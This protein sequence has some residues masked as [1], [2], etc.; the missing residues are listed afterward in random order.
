MSPFQGFIAMRC[1]FVFI[2]FLLPL[3]AFEHFEG[4]HCHPVD[5]TPDGRLLLAVNAPEGRLSVFSTANP[6]VPPQLI[7]EIPVGLEPVTVRVRNHHEAWVINEVSDSISVIDLTEG[8]CVTHLKI[9]DEPADVAFAGNLAYITCARENRIAVVDATTLAVID[10]IPLEGIFPR[11]LELSPDGTRLFVAFLLSG[12]N[13]TVLHFRD[14][15]APPPAAPHLP[16]PPQVALIVPDTD[17][18]IDYDVIDHDIAEIDLST[19]TVTRY[20]QGIGTN[21]LA[22]DAS[23]DGTLWAAATEARNLIRFEPELNGIFQESRIARIAGEN[24]SIQ[25]LNPHATTREIPAGLKEISLAQPMAI[26]ADATGA[27][28]AAFGSDRIARIDTAGNIL[29]RIDLRSTLPDTVRGPRG[30]ARLVGSSRW[31]SF[32]KLSHSLSIIDPDQAAVLWEIPLSSHL[33][34]S[35]RQ[36]EGRGFF[37]D[38]RRSGNGTVS[39]G[40]C[41]FDA[42][43]D[44]VAWDLGDPSGEMITKTGYG[45]SIGEPWPVDREM[46]PMKGPMVTQPLRGI[47]GAAPFHWRGD[48]STIHEFNTSFEKLQ[49]GE[50]LAADDM[51]KLVEYLESLRN[52][53][54]PHRLADNSLPATLNSGNPS[55]GL[56]F[57]EGA[58]ICSKCHEGPRGTNHVLD[59]FTSVLTQQPVKNSTLE[60]VYKKVFFTPEQPTSLSGFG[61]THDGSGH[62]IPRGHEYSQDRFARFPN[63]E[64][65]V[66]AYLLCIETD[67]KPAV[68]QSTSAPDPTLLSRA[69]LGDCDLIAHANIGGEA[70]GFFFDPALQLWRGDGGTDAHLDSAQLLSF[71]SSIRFLAVPPGSGPARSIDRDQDGILNRDESTPRLSLLPDL[72]PQIIDPTPGWFIQTSDD[73]RD[74]HELALPLETQ[75]RRYFR[76]RRTW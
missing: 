58:S 51:A 53:P 5:T 49:G 33:P 75:P 46:H 1:I 9:G 74:W 38:S 36:L 42:D 48:K 26:L 12:N 60:H 23:P 7:A 72:T 59:E 65:D 40:S 76:L 24:L 71:A 25:D 13:S 30:L 6:A 63:A 67:T 17:P 8:R 3:Q 61:F 52:H 68:G 62:D 54:N 44:G 15:P 57:F 73:L 28:I 32:N 4:R 47:K 10:S 31:V 34:L 16:T 45:F 64:T 69:T 70:R 35:N 27:W 2:T 39:C 50:Q 43:I 56:A 66:M 41:H 22:L 19:R 37:Y 29:H 21:L 20:H 55:T 11:A 18:R 14:A